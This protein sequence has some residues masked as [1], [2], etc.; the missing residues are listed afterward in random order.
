MVSYAIGLAP[1]YVH[2]NTSVGVTFKIHKFQVTFL[3]QTVYL[4]KTV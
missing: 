3:K 1:Y 2:M 4:V